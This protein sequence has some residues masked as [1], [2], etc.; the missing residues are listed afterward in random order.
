MLCS[1]GYISLFALYI[2]GIHTV[3]KALDTV[4]INVNIDESNPI[5]PPYPHESA[6]ASPVSP[7]L[8]PT[9]GEEA[10]VAEAATLGGDAAGNW[11]M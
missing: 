5:P 6:P 1:Q 9:P 11:Y 4:N 10:V 7:I 8:K 3:P 2:S